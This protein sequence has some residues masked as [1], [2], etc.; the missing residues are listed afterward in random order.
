M[1]CQIPDGWLLSSISS[2]EAAPAR[3]I[4]PL[5]QGRVLCAGCCAARM[6]ILAQA[7][8]FLATNFC[9]LNILIVGL[10]EAGGAG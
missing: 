9:W 5:A 6:S 1:Y 2:K 4:N 10:P 3:H 8:E 7:H